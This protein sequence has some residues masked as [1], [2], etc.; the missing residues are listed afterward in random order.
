MAHWWIERVDDGLW[1]LFSRGRFGQCEFL[2][3][4]SSRSASRRSVPVPN[5]QCACLFAVYGMG[6]RYLVCASFS[7]LY[8]NRASH[9]FSAYALRQVNSIVD[10]LFV[11]HLSVLLIF[12]AAKGYTLYPA[13][14]SALSIECISSR[15]RSVLCRAF[16]IRL[17]WP[18]HIHEKAERP[19][20]R[21]SLRCR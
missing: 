20:I 1:T 3:N 15:L 7:I 8:I 13:W 10:C 2:K 19:L 14:Q 11:F 4:H 12:V 6:L 16:N 21:V 18:S 5:S 9:R 17:R